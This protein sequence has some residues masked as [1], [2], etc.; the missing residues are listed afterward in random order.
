M[1]ISLRKFIDFIQKAETVS[2]FLIEIF[3]VS[4]G[5]KKT[6]IV[7][8]FYGKVRK[9]SIRKRMRWFESFVSFVSM[10]SER[11]RERVRKTKGG[12][13]KNEGEGEG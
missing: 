3:H 6:S 2:L 12:R 9:W 7:I 5:K 1:P 13:E 8:L 10:F 4:T 11:V